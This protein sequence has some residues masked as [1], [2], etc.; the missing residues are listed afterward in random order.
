VREKQ[1]PLLVARSAGETSH[2]LRGPEMPI[3]AP[4]RFIL[5]PR[6]N[7]PTNVFHLPSLASA[8]ATTNHA[9]T[10]SVRRSRPDRRAANFFDHDT[11]GDFRRARDLRFAPAWLRHRFGAF[12]APCGS[13]A[14]L[15]RL[16]RPAGYGFPPNLVRKG[17][18]KDFSGPSV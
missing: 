7:Q 14:L 15:L 1:P 6:G 12:H 3:P 9:L 10:E 4:A 17:A 2:A 11:E 16:R 5:D 8:R 13:S 18:R